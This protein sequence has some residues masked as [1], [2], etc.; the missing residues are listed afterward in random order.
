MII[1]YLSFVLGVF[2]SYSLIKTQSI[3]SNKTALLFKFF[4]TKV[5]WITLA[6]AL[7]YGYNNFSLKATLLGFLITILSV[8]L[9]F[10]VLG[11]FL[12]KKLGENNIRRLKIFLEYSLVFLIIYFLF[13]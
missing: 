7:Y 5:S 10:Y 1:K 6:L 12:K 13:F 4:V 3:F 11:E 8:H 9:A 2:W